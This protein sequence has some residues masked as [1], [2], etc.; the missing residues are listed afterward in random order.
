[1]PK[2]VKTTTQT[3]ARNPLI[4]TKLPTDN[5]GILGVYQS[6]KRNPNNTNNNQKTKDNGVD[7]Q[8]QSRFENVVRHFIPKDNNSSHEKH[9]LVS[10]IPPHSGATG[11][12]QTKTR[13]NRLQETVNKA[14]IPINLETINEIGDHFISI[15]D[16]KDGVKQLVLFD[17]DD[18]IMILRRKYDNKI[19]KQYIDNV[20]DENAIILL[21]YL[22]EK[23]IELGICSTSTAV[24]QSEYFYNKNTKGKKVH[25]FPN[26]KGYGGEITLNSQEKNIMKNN[27]NNAQYLSPEQKTAYKALLT[28]DPNKLTNNNKGELILT[29]YVYQK[30]VK[31]V[32]GPIDI[33]YLDNKV[34]NFLDISGHA[35]LAKLIK[36]GAIKITIIPIAATPNEQLGTYNAQTV[37]DTVTTEAVVKKLGLDKQKSNEI[38]TKAGNDGKITETNGITGSGGVTQ[39][40][41][42]NNVAQDSAGS[43]GGLK[44]ILKKT[45]SVPSKDNKGSFQDSRKTQEDL[46]NK[47]NLSQSDTNKKEPLVNNAATGSGNQDDEEVEKI[48][49]NVEKK[50]QTPPVS[51]R[52]IIN[53]NTL[54]S[55]DS[56]PPITQRASTETQGS[57]EPSR[58]VNKQQV[59]PITVSNF[60]GTNNDNKLNPDSDDKK[61]NEILD[62]KVTPSVTE[63]TSTPT[64]TNDG[65]DDIENVELV[66]DGGTNSSQT[67]PIKHTI[68]T[69]PPVTV[70]S[71]LEKQETNKSLNVITEKTLTN[72]IKNIELDGKEDKGGDKGGE[73]KVF[74]TNNNN[75]NTEANQF[76]GSFNENRKKQ[77]TN[78]SVNTNL[79][80]SAFRAY[81]KNKY[82]TQIKL[83]SCLERL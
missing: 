72:N 77:N 9:T 21:K 16:S 49:G 68:E 81:Q 46:L 79:I 55:P 65:D 50:P 28:F 36:S 14:K 61:V 48:N 71:F 56:P 27:I 60:D 37:E 51:P 22:Q 35:E 12:Q 8:K 73:N 3:G 64:P 15:V 18:C 20:D 52:T 42:H 80:N 63:G 32:T 76:L 47:L 38:L 29:H 31:G 5:G 7:G 62:K 1:M 45:N 78:G 53:G 4:N 25:K 26:I 39:H 66:P 23:G 83:L 44:S 82:Q 11:Q 75:E 30:Y 59:S 74:E 43:N 40:P 6:Y 69:S 13:K 67:V 17:I 54:V 58:Q 34:D 57:Q 10:K 70:K 2:T 33:T 19:N 24:M 41:A